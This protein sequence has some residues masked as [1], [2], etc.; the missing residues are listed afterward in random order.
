M[1]AFGP[2]PSRRL[3]RS[4]GVNNIPP[5]KCT[6]LCV[7]CQVGRTIE[8]TIDRRAFYPVQYIVEEVTN[9]VRK[10]EAAGQRIDYI[11]FVPDGEPTLDINIG[12]EISALKSLGI[13]VAVITNGSLLWREDV[14]SDLMEADLVS[15][16]IDAASE[17]VWKIINRPHKELKLNEVMEGIQEFSARYRG[18][19]IT[20]TMLI[21]GIDYA[22]ELRLIAKFIA[23]LSNVSKAYVAIPT[24]PPAENWVRSPKEE[25]LVSAYR[26]F[27]DE[28][29]EDRVEYLISYEGEDFTVIGDVR[30]DLLSTASVHPLS[31]DV[32]RAML[33]K[34]GSDWRVIEEMLRTGELVEVK[35][36]GKRFYLKKI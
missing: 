5:K 8:L 36:G 17:K 9:R 30:K 10:V 26:V 18:R 3:G 4:L 11:T 20:E 22:D 21:G 28:L 15:V 35:Y 1:I 6:Y 2:V 34:A 23:G 19:L 12:K 13:P 7:Y 24:R 31:E 25:L 32:V 33:A 16:K 29:G 27:A 14:R